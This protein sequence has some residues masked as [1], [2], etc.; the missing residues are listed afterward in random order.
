MIFYFVFNFLVIRVIL[1]YIELYKFIV[2]LVNT[3]INACNKHCEINILKYSKYK[4]EVLSFSFSTSA[5]DC[6]MKMRKGTTPVIKE[7]LM[8]SFLCQEAGETL[9]GL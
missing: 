8:M 4:F 7:I 6:G 2:S 1:S 3:E 9:L 5:M